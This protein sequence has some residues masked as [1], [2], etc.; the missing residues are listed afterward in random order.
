VG[1]ERALSELS[2]EEFL[3]HVDALLGAG[4]RQGAEAEGVPER[5]V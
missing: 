5:D 4:S 1:K 2:D 3:D